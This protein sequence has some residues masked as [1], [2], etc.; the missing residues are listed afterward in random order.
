MMSGSGNGSVVM[1]RMPSFS[2]LLL[3]QHGSPLVL[4]SWMDSLYTDEAR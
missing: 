1:T 4:S 2:Q 3:Q